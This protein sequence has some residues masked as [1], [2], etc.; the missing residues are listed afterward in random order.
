[1]ER[2]KYFESP[3]CENIKELIYY[4][5]EK[6]SENVAYIIKEKKEKEVKYKNI[7]YKKLLEDIN[8]LGTKFYELGFKNKRVAI[9]GRNRYEWAITHLANLLGGIVSVP[10]DKE[11]Q[12]DEL[13]SCLIRSKADVVVFDEKYKENIKE[14]QKRG[15]GNLKEYIC[16][17]KLEGYK[18][19][20]KLL[21]EGYKLIEEGKKEYVEAEIDSY[22]MNILLFTSGTTSKSKAVMTKQYCFKCIFY[23]ISR[24]NLTNRCKLSIFA[25]PSCLWLNGAN[26]NACSRCNNSISRWITICSTKSKR[27]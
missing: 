19:I 24:R 21:E 8:A 1:M 14:I 4:A 18:D 15:N 23:V 13:E 27:I 10:L 16:M 2:E 17:S 9:V 26:S 7:T 6:Y 22:K 3:N 5:V 25:M 20:E 12:V 11:L